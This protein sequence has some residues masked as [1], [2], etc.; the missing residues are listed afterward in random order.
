MTYIR[1]TFGNVIG[2]NT[3]TSNGQV[4]VAD[5]TGLPAID[6]SQLLNLPSSGGGGFTYEAKTASFIAVKDKFYSVES[7][8]G[9]TVTVTLP[10]LP[11][12]GDRIKIFHHGDGNLN[13]Q[14]LSIQ[15]ELDPNTGVVQTG[16]QIYNGS[17]RTVESRSLIELIATQIYVANPAQS[18]IWE[19]VVTPQLEFGED[20]LTSDHEHLVYKAS[21]KQMVGVSSTPIIISQ[22]SAGSNLPDASFEE[23]HKIYLCTGNC[24]NIKL[25]S[26]NTSEH[27]KFTIKRMGSNNIT[28]ETATAHNLDGV[29]G[30]AVLTLTATNPMITVVGDGVNSWYTV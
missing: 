28:I 9:A 17:Y 7:A 16:Y 1:R 2:L 11:T 4:I 23:M 20:T 8:S 26:P 30:N 27:C 24:T 19:Y 14:E 25:P 22:T 13:L 12:L 5:A 18:A 6:G 3:G 10:A 21:T 15:T 29:S